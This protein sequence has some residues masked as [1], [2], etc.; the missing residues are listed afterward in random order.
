MALARTRQSVAVHR[1]IGFLNGH[2]VARAMVE[3]RRALH[4]NSVC[5]SPVLNSQLE[6]TDLAKLYR[7]HLENTAAPA[8]FA[9][10]LQLRTML[11]LDFDE[12]ERIEK[13]VMEQGAM[14]SI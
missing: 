3:I 10:L 9:T 1:A 5:R 12:A 6:A 14:Y 2:N 7:L 4:E 13:E 11:D 8:D